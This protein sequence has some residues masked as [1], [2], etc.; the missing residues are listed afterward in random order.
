MIIG[1]YKSLII[2]AHSKKTNKRNEFETERRDYDSVKSYVQ[3]Y[4]PITL[5][6]LF[7]RKFLDQN[8]S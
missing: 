1:Y 8:K 7:E 6:I 3:I 2:L 5:L 4:M